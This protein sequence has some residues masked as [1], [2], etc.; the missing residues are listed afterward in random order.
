[1]LLN[2]SRVFHHLSQVGKWLLVPF[3]RERTPTTKTKKT[4]AFRLSDQK[5]NS[6]FM[7][8]AQSSDLKHIPETPQIFKKIYCVSICD[9]CLYMTCVTRAF[10]YN[11]AHVPWHIRGGQRS[12][13]SHLRPWVQAARAFTC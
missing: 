2:M 4:H 3:P 10:T 8:C 12:A 11:G 13:C 9:V 6:R 1:M 5:T 7:C